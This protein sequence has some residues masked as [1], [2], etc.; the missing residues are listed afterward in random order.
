MLCKW[1]TYHTGTIVFQTYLGFTQRYT[2]DTDNE[3]VS[4]WG[5]GCYYGTRLAALLYRSNPLGLRGRDD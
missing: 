4:Q 1:G 2:A 3:A 5:R